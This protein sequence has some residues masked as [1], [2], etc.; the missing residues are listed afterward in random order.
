MK[1]L[2]SCV[3]NS[4]SGFT[5]ELTLFKILFQKNEFVD[6]SRLQACPWSGDDVT[7]S[8]KD[9]FRWYT[10]SGYGQVQLSHSWQKGVAEL[11][12]HP[13]FPGSLAV[14]SSTGSWRRWCYFLFSLCSSTVHRGSRF[15]PVQCT[16]EALNLQ[17][18]RFSV[19]LHTPT[20]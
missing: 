15:E 8:G 10:G 18:R 6:M 5:L 20:L 2:L 13:P 4:E 3:M 11:I 14:A 12:L 19:F 7:S 9:P 17:V 16:G 1:S